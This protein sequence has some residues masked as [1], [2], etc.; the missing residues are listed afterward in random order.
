MIKRAV[1]YLYAAVGFGC[2]AVFVAALVCGVCCVFS[3]DFA[4]A[5]TWGGAAFLGFIGRELS[6][7]LLLEEVRGDKEKA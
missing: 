4:G 1:P 5:L 6:G 7:S 3:G 2:A